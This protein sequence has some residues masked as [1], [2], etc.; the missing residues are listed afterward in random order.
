MT[1]SAAAARLRGHALTEGSARFATTAAI[2]I[3][4]YFSLLHVAFVYVSVPGGDHRGTWALAAVATYLPLHVRHV[5]FAAHEKRPPGGTWTLTVMAVIVIG[6]LPLVGSAWVM[7]LSWLAVSALIVVRRPWSYA[8]AIG[9]LAA[10][11]PVA[12]LLGDPTHVADWFALSTANRTVTLFVL[13]WLAAAIRR[14]QATRQALAEDAVLRERLRIDG[15]LRRTVATALESIVIRGQRAAALAGGDSA[16]LEAELRALIEDS[17]TTLAETRRMVRGYQQVSLQ[18][19][20][21][22][23]AALLA[24][25]GIDARLSLPARSLPSAAEEALR[26]ALRA[27]LARLLRDDTPPTACLITVTCEGG[28]ARLELRTDRGSPSTMVVTA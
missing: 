12:L 18:A 7:E 20:L 5:W 3:A 13:V 16:A 15:E 2:V 1:G 19:E 25:A 11:W 14:L 6:A 28:Q 21:D 22:T 17:R 4:F 8:I 9:L 23:A 27:A 26:A 24:A 10:A